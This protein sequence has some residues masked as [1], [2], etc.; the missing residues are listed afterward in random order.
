[1]SALPYA[2]FDLARDAEEARRFDR[3]ANIYHRGQDLAWDGRAVLKGLC[4]KHGRPRIAPHQVEAFREVFGPILWGELA[5][6]KISAQLADRLEPLEAKMAATSQAHD[7]ARHFYVMH[8]YLELATGSVPK[9]VHPA[10]EKLLG[11]VL[12]TDDL[13]CKLMGMQMQV[14]TTALTIFQRAREANLCPVLTEL[15]PYFEKDEARHVG[16]GT[17]CLPILMRRMNRLEGARLTA[18]ALRVTF[19]LIASNQAM[20]EPLRTLGID[21]REVLR[22]AKSKQM[23]VWEDLWASTGKPGT[24]AGDVLGRVLEAVANAAW[25]PPEDKNLPGRVRALWKGLTHGVDGVE[26]SI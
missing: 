6:W 12:E 4:E 15:L 5:A 9:R 16:L 13:A 3:A 19:W 1:M 10:G 26:T 22:L 21:P 18:F 8:D 2:M 23:I 25:P 14:E 20:Q 11:L 24:T 7:E 17:Q